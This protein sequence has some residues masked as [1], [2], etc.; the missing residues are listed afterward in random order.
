MVTAAYSYLLDTDRD[1][2]FG[3]DVSADVQVTK[4][5]MGLNKPYDHMGRV[6][7]AVVTLKNV[8]G[9]YSPAHAS[10]L[11]GFQPGVVSRYQ[12]TYDG[13]TVNRFTG[14]VDP[15]EVAVGT[16]GDRK[17]DVPARGYFSRM[18]DVD[19][20]VGYDTNIKTGAAIEELINNGGIYP[21]GFFGWLAGLPG[22]SEAGVTTRVAGGV[23][24]YAILDEG[25]YTIRYLGDAYSGSVFDALRETVRTD[26]GWLYVNGDGILVFIDNRYRYEDL[27]SAVDATFTGT[28][29]LLDPAPEYEYGGRLV[30]RLVMKYRPRSVSDSLTTVGSLEGVTIDLEPGETQEVVIPFADS[31]GNSI[32]AYDV[33]IPSDTD[34]DWDAIS[35]QPIPVGKQLIYVDHDA[36]SDFYVDSATVYANQIK[37][38]FGRIATPALTWPS[39]VQNIRVRGK[40]IALYNEGETILQDDESIFAYGLREETQKFSLLDDSQYAID[41]AQNELEDRKSPGFGDFIEISILANKSHANMVLVRDIAVGDRW[42]ISE[43]HLGISGAEYFVVGWREEIGSKFEHILTAILEP[44]PKARWLAGTAGFSEAGTTTYSGLGQAL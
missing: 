22:Y 39:Y 11:S 15:P 31:V 7:E 36:S 10:A 34:G 12:M 41:W 14:W 38:V 23:S 29:L 40:P 17:T 2:T 42:S 16:Y 8:D 35:S 43:P 44:V 21:P 27:P 33:E 20:R 9:T 25:A 32:A 1:G 13:V 6:A 5:R 24:D 37:V 19:A 18:Q 30:N 3:A 28:D 4:I 26:G